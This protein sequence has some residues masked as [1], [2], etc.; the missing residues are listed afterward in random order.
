MSIWNYIIKNG[1]KFNINS[2]IGKQILRNYII[3]LN[4]GAYTDMSEQKGEKS[5]T[6][7]AEQA[8]APYESEVSPVSTI[9][10]TEVVYQQE[11]T[12]VNERMEAVRLVQQ[13]I[14]ERREA[15]R[16]VGQL[17]DDGVD[18]NDINSVEAHITLINYDIQILNTL[19][20][21]CNKLIFAYDEPHDDDN[22]LTEYEKHFFL[23]LD[24]KAFLIDII[25]S[26]NDTDDMV[27]IKRPLTEK[28]IDELMGKGTN[29]DI[30]SQSTNP[31]VKRLL[32]KFMDMLQEN[33]LHISTNILKDRKF[34][35]F[36]NNI[37]KIVRG[38]DYIEQ[39]NINTITTNIEV[40][41]I[42]DND[43]HDTYSEPVT[44]I[45][46]DDI[47]YVLKP[48]KSELDIKIL[49]LFNEINL[50]N[51]EE[52]KL[53]YYKIY[54][55]PTLDYS[56]WE[57]ITTTA[58]LRPVPAVYLIDF[59]DEERKQI[60]RKNLEFLNNISKKIG[61]TDLHYQNVILSNNTFYPIDLESI[62]Y[63]SETGL[64]TQSKV[65]TSETELHTPKYPKLN[66][67]TLTLIDKF[68]QDIHNVKVRYIPIYT[69][70]LKDYIS[71][72]RP[73]GGEDELIKSYMEVYVEYYVKYLDGSENI[74]IPIMIDILRENLKICKEHHIIPYFY[75]YERN[76]YM[77]SIF[78]DSPDI[79]LTIRIN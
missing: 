15:V 3:T 13:L 41:K 60:Q 78:E 49:E 34:I 26:I 75:T 57:F 40:I 66:D 37:I 4:G 71:I 6:H 21:I 44:H 46:I 69:S 22:K 39:K 65:Y 38:F 77:K 11:L 2:A 52:L 47:D 25:T 68:N 56:L 64:Y 30:P 16:L 36:K 54:S 79:L 9:Q 43:K 17:I 48:R 10:S 58:E 55:H 50:S 70:D 73:P 72:N 76:I 63:T 20:N 14:D 45:K 53:P 1:K 19:R 5:G 28:L 12:I 18:R 27:D 29:V 62:N 7:T 32:D 59:E 23:N 8:A 67:Y 33:Y 24:I 74:N 61:L 51:V 31:R 42:F 35:I